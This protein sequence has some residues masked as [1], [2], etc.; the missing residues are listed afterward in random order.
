MRFQ[1]RNKE[2]SIVAEET[3]I[4]RGLKQARAFMSRHF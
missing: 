1:L 2:A 3:V 4:K